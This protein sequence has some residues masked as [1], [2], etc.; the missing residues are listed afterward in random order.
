MAH[1]GARDPF[2]G[3]EVADAKKHPMP[4]ASAS[5]RTSREPVLEASA[6]TGL[7]MELRDRDAEDEPSCAYAGDARHGV[8]ESPSG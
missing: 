2:P 8:V 4:F 1:E 3:P 5:S 6:R 7:S